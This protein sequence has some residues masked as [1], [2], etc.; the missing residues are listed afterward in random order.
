M[1]S[2]R[3]LLAS[4][5][6]ALRKVVTPSLRGDD[7]HST[8]IS[9]ATYSPWRV[10]AEYRATL[11]EI[12]GCTLLDEMR[13][14]ELWQLADQVGHLWG[15]GIEIGCWRGG[16]GCLIAHRLSARRPSATMFLCDTF[17]GVVKAGDR[18]RDYRGGEHDDAD[19]R[20]VLE[21]ARRMGLKNVEVLVGIFPEDTGSQV[22]DRAFAF[23]HI[24]VDVY[25]GA[26]DAFDWLL[27]RL[28]PGGVVVFDDYGSTATGGI[29]ALVDEL[30]GHPDLAVVRN[31]NGQAVAVRRAGTTPAP[32][33][34]GAVGGE[35]PGRS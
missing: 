3:R 18:D 10:D 29:R 26:R 15:D 19:E 8:L 34:E 11:E 33:S 31:L 30:H 24:D 25:D 20:T 17:A 6:H 16:A 12:S 5:V 13:L 7:S 32:P 22:A 21:L 4:G 1:D 23:A 9:T 28:V 35:T 14:H 27:P 2:L